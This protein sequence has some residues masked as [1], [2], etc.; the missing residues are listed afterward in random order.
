[1]KKFKGTPGPWAV[2]ES[3]DEVAVAMGT[4]I[5]SPYEYTCGHVWMTEGAYWG[6]ACQEDIANAHL[7]AAAPE[8]LGALQELHAA[9][10][11]LQN[12]EDGVAVDARAAIN[13]ALGGGE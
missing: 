6:E 4:A 8:L 12:S 13:K 1:M 5:G 2:T 3:T 10:C 7:I 9:W 11:E